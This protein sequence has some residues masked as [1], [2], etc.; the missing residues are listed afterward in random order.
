[1]PAQIIGFSGSPIK[2]SNTDRLVQALL[3]ASG[4]ETEF[5]KLLKHNIRPCIVCLGC[6]ADNVCAEVWRQARELGRTMADKIK[7]QTAL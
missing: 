3:D 6:T 1:M 7:A 5:V 2:N 4:L